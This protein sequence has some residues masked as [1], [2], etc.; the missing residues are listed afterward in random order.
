MI[1]GGVIIV[2]KK[3]RVIER[4]KYTGCDKI[5]YV[6]CN[7]NKAYE[8]C[9]KLEDDDNDGRGFFY[10][11][12]RFGISETDEIHE[13][14]IFWYKQAAEEELATIDDSE[15]YEIRKVIASIK[16]IT[17]EEKWRF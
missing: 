15:E 13:A 12:N 4:I 2:K 6:I 8:Y 14:T 17:D 7:K 1:L 11:D 5:G 16:L 9:D 3:E 10:E